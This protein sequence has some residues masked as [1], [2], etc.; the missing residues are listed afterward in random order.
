MGCVVAA[1]LT[2]A[3]PAALPLQVQHCRSLYALLA[4]MHCSVFL[5]GQSSASCF[6]LYYDPLVCAEEGRVGGRCG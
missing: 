4:G 2:H 1:A 6:T 3:T 5:E